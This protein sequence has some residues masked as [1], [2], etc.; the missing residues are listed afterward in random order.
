M[1]IRPDLRRIGSLIAALLLGLVAAG[2]GMWAPPAPARSELDGKPRLRPDCFG[3]PLPP[4][5]VARVG[6]IRWWSGPASGGCPLVYTP[7]GKCLVSCDDGK[8]VRFLDAATGKELRRLEPPGDVFSFALAP[9]GKTLVTAAA[10]RGGL[11]LWEA[12][13]GKELRRIA[14]Q[15]GTVEIAFSRDGKTFAAL[16]ERTGIRL[17]DTATWK[18][19]RRLPGR[20]AGLNG[21]LA[22][23]PD[24]KTLI[25]GDRRVIRWWDIGTGQV[26][27][28][29]DKGL[30]R[31][32][33]QLAVSPDGKRLSVVVQGNVLYLW[34]AATGKEVQRTVLPRSRGGW[35]LCFSPDS[36]TLACGNGDGWR[37]NV[38]VFLAADTGRELRRWDEDADP[39]SRMAFSP[40][41]KVLAQTGSDVIWLRDAV[42]GKPFRPTPGT[43]GSVMAVRFSRDGKALIAG[44]RGGRSGSWDPLTGKQV[45]AM[46]GPPKDFRTL[47]PAFYRSTALIADGSKAALADARGALYVWETATGKLCCRITEP[48]P[49]GGDGPVFSADGK[50]VALGHSDSSLRLWDTTNGKLL[51][52]FPQIKS[53]FLRPLAF[54][55]DRR[56]LALYFLSTTAFTEAKEILLWDTTTGKERKRLPWPEDTSPASVTFTADGKRLIVSY[57]PQWSE[58]E[59]R[60]RIGLCVWDLTSGRELHRCRGVAGAIALSPDE[61]TLAAADGKTVRLWELPSGKER[62]RFTGHRKRIVS[63]AFSPDGRLLASGSQDHTVLV[64]AL[65]R[66][67]SVS[68]GHSGR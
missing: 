58:G 24:G 10:R 15:P 67:G 55:P 18:G 19:I 13:T 50:V 2:A 51:R 68:D 59:G 5:A 1:S 28:R 32:F 53:R 44:C 16:A 8:A 6:T 39:T 35:Y 56:I 9:D 52:S 4:G 31:G 66:A 45:A 38:T 11:R 14:D 27:R 54:S 43:P 61:R 7:D 49:C 25:T 48:P 64:W 22:F 26:V 3:D 34:D 47:P 36:R 46:Q 33:Y 23:L 12:A 62:G 20:E 42:T 63:L 21:F 65:Q 37:G 60:D 29:L 41:G 17:W 57:D 30:N 40:D